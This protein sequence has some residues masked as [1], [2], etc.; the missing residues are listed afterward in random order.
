M[1]VRC[2]IYPR[3]LLSPRIN[4]V[5]VVLVLLSAL[6][7]TDNTFP[8]RLLTLTK[9]NPAISIGRSSKRR[10]E[11]EPSADNAFFD[12]PVMSREHAELHL[13]AEKRAVT[14]KDTGSLHGTL[15]NKLALRPTETR[16]VK[17]G[18]IISF[19]LAIDRG[20]DKFTPHEVEARITW[21]TKTLVPR[22]ASPSAD[23]ANHDSRRPS[24]NVITYRVPDDT[25][26][27]EL[28]DKEDDLPEMSFARKVIRENNYHVLDYKGNRVDLTTQRLPPISSFD[29]PSNANV[30]VDLTLDEPT[31]WDRLESSVSSRPTH[32]SVD[33]FPQSAHFKSLPIGYAQP[34]S[35]I[36]QLVGATFED[37]ADE[38]DVSYVSH[39]EQSP[40]DEDEL[41]DDPEIESSDDGEGADFNLSEIEVSDEEVDAKADEEAGE[42]AVEELEK[43]ADD[44]WGVDDDDS[45]GL[46]VDGVVP[47][48]AAAIGGPEQ[49]LLKPP[50]FGEEPSKPHAFAFPT[51]E[52]RKLAGQ[53]SFA[54]TDFSFMVD[55]NAS[56]STAFFSS[57]D[58]DLAYKSEKAEFL[59]AREENRKTL[60]LPPKTEQ[61]NKSSRPSFPDDI[62]LTNNPDAGLTNEWL[63]S[64]GDFLNEPLKDFKATE[65]AAVNKEPVLDESS[66]YQF[67][68]SK[69][70]AGQATDAKATLPAE[71]S[72]EAENNGKPALK[73]KSEDISGSSVEEEEAIVKSEP[74]PKSAPAPREEVDS[75]SAAIAQPIF[76][77]RGQLS[78]NSLSDPIDRAPKRL[79]RTVEAVGYAAIGGIAVMSAL[80]ATAPQL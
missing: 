78:E 6:T 79:R 23:T 12:C 13:D 66:A 16:V 15:L 22:V 1:R 48:L 40:S 70:A 20:A 5:L 57:E 31:S 65:V 27:E 44:F 10:L 35:G 43:E 25:D 59:K 14:I 21:Q 33:G 60:G 69:K 42:R 62:V 72:K 28:S 67:Q 29:A 77:A 51:I 18:D 63:R 4:I 68:M 39:S 46:D 26:V 56:K 74:E 36:A 53:P 64:G 24:S 11:L 80:I 19:G 71:P 73:R 8:E 41:S 7:N 75:N 34:A 3:T 76:I 54:P 32:L 37:L 47:E 61:V 38:D 30:M 58:K 45:A 2:Y 50:T 55:A 9:D 52:A 17:T 49:T